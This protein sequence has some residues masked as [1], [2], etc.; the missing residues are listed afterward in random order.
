M[1]KEVSRWLSAANAT[2]WPREDSESAPATPSIPCSS[3]PLW[4]ADA[5]S[6]LWKFFSFIVSF[7]C[8]GRGTLCS[9]VAQ[10][11][12]GP[13]HFLP[14]SEDTTARFQHAPLSL[15]GVSEKIPM[16]VHLRGLK[17]QTYLV[18]RMEKQS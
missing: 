12:G 6:H 14:S 9:V 15:W 1:C 10:L 8:Q 5:A 16:S 11:R 4:E 2:L 18:T 17:L 3:S 13:D 7:W